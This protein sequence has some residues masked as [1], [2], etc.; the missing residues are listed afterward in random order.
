MTAAEAALVLPAAS[1]A[2]AV[3]LWQPV[4]RVPVV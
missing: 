3:K 1:T 2:L 4:V